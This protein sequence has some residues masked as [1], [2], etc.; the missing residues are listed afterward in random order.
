MRPS[1]ITCYAAR[2]VASA[3]C[4]T[5]A[6]EVRNAAARVLRPRTRCRGGRTPRDRRSIR[7]QRQ[8][9]PDAA[10]ARLA[11]GRSRVRDSRSRG[12]L[13]EAGAVAPVLRRAN[14]AHSQ[15]SLPDGRDAH[16]DP[17]AV[18]RARSARIAAGSA[19]GRGDR[20]AS[21]SA[22]CCFTSSGTASRPRDCSRSVSGS[23]VPRT[24]EWF[25]LHTPPSARSLD[26]CARAT[27]PLLAAA[28]RRGLPAR[29]AIRSRPSVRTT[30]GLRSRRRPRSASSKKSDRARPRTRP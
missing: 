14:R 30:G 6:R 22:A 21:R 4:G 7:E 5:S 9:R 26:T 23:P 29:R 15:F 11:R 1:R 10:A 8:P 18:V 19:A 13:A 28:P 12:D 24:A 2:T 25:A 3:A 16:A 27:R 17:R 20:R